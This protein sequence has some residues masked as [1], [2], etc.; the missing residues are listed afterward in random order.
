MLAIN[1]VE[2][3]SD[4]PIE[5]NLRE[6]ADVKRHWPDRA[7]IVSAMVESKP[8]AWADIV[9]RIEDTGADAIELNYGC[10]HGMSERGMGSRRRSG[11]RVL[12]AHH[13]LG[14]Q[15]ARI[16]II[17]KLTPNITNIVSPGESCGG[18][19]RGCSF[20]HQHDQLDRWRRSRHASRSL[21]TSAAKADMAAT[22]DLP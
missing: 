22:R 20:A 6:I 10:P 1:N 17:V 13:R 11:A 5:I 16:P 18:G 4:R 14:K 2:L 7:V 12:R 8:E 9:R 15:A 3:I 21:P 19:R